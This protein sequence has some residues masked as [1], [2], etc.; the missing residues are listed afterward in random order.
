MARSRATPSAPPPSFAPGARVEV[1][2]E[3]WI[4]RSAK[5]TGTG[6][7]AVHV[8]GVSEIVR[9]RQAIFSTQVSEL[10]PVHTLSFVRDR[11]PDEGARQAFDDGERKLMYVAATRAREV[12]VVVGYGEASVIVS[13]LELEA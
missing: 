4:V 12:L 2:D 11:L 7:T 5:P 1:R 6:A 13:S 10:D 8:V 9:N 3:E